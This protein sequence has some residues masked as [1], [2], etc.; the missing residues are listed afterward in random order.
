MVQGH[1]EEVLARI[2]GTN[3]FSDELVAEYDI[4]IRMLHACGGGV[5]LGA[6]G[7][8]DLCRFIGIA[9]KPVEASVGDTVDWQRVKV[10]DLLVVTTGEGERIGKFCGRPSA[11]TVS[12][13]FEDQEWVSEF[14]ARLIK[15]GPAPDP[16]DVAVSSPEHQKM[17]SDPV[18]E[19]TPVAMEINTDDDCCKTMKWSLVPEGSPVLIGDDMTEGE[20][21]SLA[22]PKGCL[23]VSVGGRRHVV[24]AS[25]VI[26]KEE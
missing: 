17:L 5:S 25:D 16:I 10:N 9:H 26:R 24:E 11:G 23:I 1:D 8:I 7:L 12:V 4:R 21:I 15:P 14:P 19:I 13:Q 6:L 3:K 20:F 2:L 18:A 22:K